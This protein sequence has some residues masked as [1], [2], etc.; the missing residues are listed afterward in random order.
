MWMVLTLTVTGST[1]PGGMPAWAWLLWIVPALPLM[2]S[3]GLAAEAWRERRGLE[4][5]MSH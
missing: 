4:R 3:A 5:R 1:P 2:L